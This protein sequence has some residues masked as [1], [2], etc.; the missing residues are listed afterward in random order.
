LVR[1]QQNDTARSEICP[2]SLARTFALYDRPRADSRQNVWRWAERRGPCDIDIQRSQRGRYGSDPGKASL[3]T[4]C[5]D[6]A[7]LRVPPPGC[8]DRFSRECG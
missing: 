7:R 8:S 4:S 6:G 3:S 2:Q 5:R 1:G